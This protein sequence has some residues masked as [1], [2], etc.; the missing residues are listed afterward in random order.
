MSAC[1]RRVSRR[2]W[3]SGGNGGLDALRVQTRESISVISRDREALQWREGG[4]GWSG[5]IGFWGLCPQR[6]RTPVIKFSGLAAWYRGVR[7][8]GS[9][10]TYRCGRGEETAGQ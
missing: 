9:R 1:G 10:A 2:R 7:G 6:W 8:R 5:I 4:A 3:P